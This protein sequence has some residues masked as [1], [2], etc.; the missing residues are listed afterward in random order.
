M[1]V[2]S[3]AV[4]GGAAEDRVGSVE[5]LDREETDEAVGDGHP[6][7]GEEP[8]GAG[9]ESVGVAVGAADGEEERRAAAVLFF[10]AEDLVGEV[11]AGEGRG[12]LVE[13]VEVGVGGERGEEGGL[14]ADLGD[15]EGAE[16]AQALAVLV[17]RGAEVVLLQAA[18]DDQ[19]DLDGG[20]PGASSCLPPRCERLRGAPAGCAARRS[21]GPRDRS[22][23][24]SGGGRR[25]R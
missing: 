20:F 25:G 16:G 21:T 8:A 18:D 22:A 3:L 14:V 5:L 10:V 4:V 12:A 23:R 17:L 1:M 9:A 19:R 7:E 15:V 2:F 6:A 11:E 24:G 13:G